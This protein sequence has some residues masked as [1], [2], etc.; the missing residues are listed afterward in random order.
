MV[1]IP[2][3]A[4]TESLVGLYKTSGPR[5]RELQAEYLKALKDVHRNLKIIS[6]A[7]QEVTNA[8]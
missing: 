1:D 8:K 6:E 4:Y 2:S 5:L 7:I 3:K